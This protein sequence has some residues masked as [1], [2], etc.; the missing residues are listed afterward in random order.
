M[1][2]SFC[3]LFTYPLKDKSDDDTESKNY[4]ADENTADGVESIPDDVESTAD[5]VRTEPDDSVQIRS[6]RNV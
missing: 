3:Y 1:P 2:D 5:D 4:N 6:L